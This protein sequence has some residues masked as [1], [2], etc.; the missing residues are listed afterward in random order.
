MIIGFVVYLR[1]LRCLQPEG[2]KIDIIR[3]EW[4]ACTIV[5]YYV[6]GGCNSC[7]K[8]VY[9]SAKKKKNGQTSFRVARGIWFWHFFFRDFTMT[10]CTI[11]PIFEQPTIVF[12]LV[13]FTL[14]F[15]HT[16]RIK[17]KKTERKPISNARHNSVCHRVC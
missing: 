15:L 13:F 7:R 6:R 5:L 12:T 1:G 2:M 10:S 3:N 4:T 17:K 11:W 16:A 8:C 14:L 9:A